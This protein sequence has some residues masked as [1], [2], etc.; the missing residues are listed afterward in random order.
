[1]EDDEDDYSWAMR[2]IGD[3]AEHGVLD[4]TDFQE[5]TESVLYYHLPRLQKEWDFK[6]RS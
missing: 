5:L 6:R 2:V 1:V 4:R 3:C